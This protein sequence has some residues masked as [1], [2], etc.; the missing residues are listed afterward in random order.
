M[1]RDNQLQRKDRGFSLVELM[2]VLIIL[3]LLVAIVVPK[4]SKFLKKGQTEAAKAQV[5]Q[6]ETALRSYYGDMGRYPATDE[7][8]KALIENPDGSA[9]WAGPYLEK[10]QVPKD[11][12]KN[13]YIYKCPGT[14]KPDDFD[15]SSKGQDG[16][17]ETADDINN[18]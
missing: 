18:W 1:K 17:E 14:R 7:G 13:D 3:G 16:Q 8:L 5:Q 11:P 2:V 4:A 6:L 15:L 10:N 12:W 9:N